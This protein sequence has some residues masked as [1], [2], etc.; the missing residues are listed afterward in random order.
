LRFA[1]NLSSS[2]NG[3]RFSVY[4]AALKISAPA[5]TPIPVKK[6]P[7]TGRA[8]ILRPD[9]PAGALGRRASENSPTRIAEV[10][11]MSH[12]RSGELTT[13]ERETVIRE[14]EI[15]EGLDGAVLSLLAR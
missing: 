8:P 6:V 9:G 3:I 14:S 1:V 13:P 12:R 7:G 15:A 11:P 5:L 2:N 4:L 10:S